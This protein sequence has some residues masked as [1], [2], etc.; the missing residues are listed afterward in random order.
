MNL[1]MSSFCRRKVQNCVCSISPISPKRIWKKFFKRLLWNAYWL[2][3]RFFRKPIQDEAFKTFH[4]FWTRVC[5]ALVFIILIFVHFLHNRV[6]DVIKYLFFY[7]CKFYRFIGDKKLGIA[8][9]M[10]S[11][12]KSEKELSHNVHEISIDNLLQSRQTDKSTDGFSQLEFLKTG[13]PSKSQK[14]MIEEISTKTPYFE[15]SSLEIEDGKVIS[16]K[17]SL[18]GIKSSNECQLDVSEV[19]HFWQKHQLFVISHTCYC[20]L[21]I[22]WVPCVSE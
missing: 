13:T 4:T 11:F 17:I 21:A 20:S 14:P 10:K 18:P 19:S 2:G 15:M 5:H 16:L 3:S 1:S 12:C 22:S 7:I 8:S 6:I 9:L